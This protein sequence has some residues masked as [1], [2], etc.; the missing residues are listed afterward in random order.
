MQISIDGRV[1]APG[2][3]E[4][5]TVLVV[6]DDPDIAAMI[7]LNLRNEGFLAEHAGDGDEALRRLRMREYSLLLL[8]LML[9]GTDGFGV[10][11]EVRENLKLVPG[12]NF[13]LFAIALKAVSWYKSLASS[14]F[15][16][17]L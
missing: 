14:V 17:K 2:Q 7:S 16:V 8:D 4:A 10:C 11:R 12:S 1:P 5:K 3:R 9:P 6:E 13:S 15:C